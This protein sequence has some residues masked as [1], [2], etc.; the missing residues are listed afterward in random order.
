MPNYT[1]SP[2]S[3]G[4]K[5]SPGKNQV[6]ISP[7]EGDMA[8]LVIEGTKKG[9]QTA[10]L[11]SVGNLVVSS[12]GN[13]GI[14][15]SPSA[16]LHVVS[17]SEQLRLGYDTTN[18]VKFTVGSDNTFTI[19]PLVNS[20]SALKF[21]NAAGTTILNIDS[22]N[23]RVGIG[24]TSP[25]AILHAVS[26]TQ[27]QFRL[28]Y[29]ESAYVDF[30]VDSE[31]NLVFRNTAADLVKLT[32]N[33]AGGVTYGGFSYVDPNRDF[34]LRSASG[35]GIA[36]IV[37]DGSTPSVYIKSD[38]NLGIGTTTPGYPLEVN[39]NIKATR[40]GLGTNPDASYSLYAAGSV[41]G[42]TIVGDSLRTNPSGGTSLVRL[43][44]DSPA[45]QTGDLLQWAVNSVV[46]G[47]INSAGSL[48]IGTTSGFGGGAGV[49]GIANAATVPTSNPSGGGVL[50]V[51]GGALKY[52]GSS[53]TV[54]TIANA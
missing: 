20:T 3:F 8:G 10:S 29:S 16:P 48:G 21:T 2:F 19:T 1:S 50:Y 25:A 31:S 44:I 34:G 47:V 46:L 38:G 51:E 35:K 9:T 12:S 41:R 30:K 14:G 54:T 36:L 42:L 23:S 49:I 28:G 5:S 52:R 22:T 17:T 33:M 13:V 15:A 7:I 4:G 27:P 37:N 53:G 45:G 6:Y 26:T 18:A 32:Q 43:G 11:L 39:G 24:I 40:I